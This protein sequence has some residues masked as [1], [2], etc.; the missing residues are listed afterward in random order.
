MSNIL[1][2]LICPITG[3]VLDDPIIVPCCT[4]V[5]S[6]LPLAQALELRPECPLC[7]GSLTD[8]KPLTAPKNLAIQ[9]I[10]DSLKPS[11][12]LKHTNTWSATYSCINDTLGELTINLNNSSF[13]VNPSL[14]VVVADTSGSMGGSPWA[15]VEQALLYIISVARQNPLIKVEII[16]YDSTAK[17]L[18]LT[19]NEQF[20]TNLVKSMYTGGGTNFSS[21]FQKIIELLGKYTC[22]EQ[23]AINNVSNV[24]I[25]FLT[26]GQD[27]SNNRI[28]LV[29]NFKTSLQ[30]N[31]TGA[32]NV[33]SVGFSQACDRTFLEA[34]FKSG[35]Q[36]GTF[37]YADPTDNGDTLCSKLQSIYEI[38][39][40]SSS[41]KLNLQLSGL[42]NLNGIDN[43]DILFPIDSTGKGCYKLWCNTTCDVL[44]LIVNDNEIKIEKRSN[45]NLLE[46]WIT[47]QVDN[48]ATEVYNLASNYRS[49]DLNKFK[50]AIINTKIDNIRLKTKN[51]ETITRLDFI[52]RQLNGLLVGVEVNL[53]TMSNQ[54]FGSVYGSTQPTTNKI[55]HTPKPTLTT[56]P[57][58]T[59]RRVFYT[60]NNNN[61]GRNAISEFIV[62]LT[63]NRLTS[64]ILTVID[65]TSP[66]ALMHPD[67]NGNTAFHLLAYT[68]CSNILEHLL[69]KFSK[70]LDLNILNNDKETPL[71][72]AVKGYGYFKSMNILFKHGALI[73]DGRS[74]SLQKYCISGGFIKTAQLIGEMS[75][76]C[77]EVDHS[78]SPEFVEILFNKML[79]CPKNL[80]KFLSVTMDKLMISIVIQ[81][82][83]MGVK[84]SYQQV[85]DYCFPKRPDAD[86]TDKY[87][88]LTD[89]VI[90]KYPYLLALRD[91]NGENLLFHACNRGSLPHVKYYLSHGVEIE[92]AN[93]LGNTPLWISCAKRY[94]CIIN[95]LLNSGANV[96]HMNIKGNTPLYSVCQRG[97]LK[98]AETLL[99]YGAI[100]EHNDTKR[101]SLLLVACRNGQSDI[102]RLLL[103]YVSPSFVNFK[104]DIDGFSAIFSSAEAGHE[105]CIQVLY[106]Y[107]V[108][109]NSK[110]DDNNPIIKG[111]T[112]LHLACY[113]GR[114]KAVNRL[115]S[116]GCKVNIT[117]YYGQTPLHLAVIQG[118]IE[119]VK[120]LINYKADKNIKDHQGMTA[121]NYCRDNKVLLD[122]LSNP[123][124]TYLQ[125]LAFNSNKKEILE[126]LAGCNVPSLFHIKDLLNTSE[127]C[128]SPLRNAIF[129]ND[130]DLV[131]SL[132]SLGA[133]FNTSSD[134]VND[135]TLIHLIGNQRIKSLVYTEPNPIHMENIAMAKKIDVENNMCLNLLATPKNFIV[136]KL[137][138]IHTRMSFISQLTSLN[139][140]FKPITNTINI[141]DIK[142]DNIDTMLWHTK[143]EVLVETAIGS[144]LTPLENT[145]LT[146]YINYLSSYINNYYNDSKWLEWA[147]LLY[148]AVDKL[149]KL[150]TEV[151]IGVK[152]LDRVLFKVGNIV[153]SPHFVSASSIWRV[154]TE[155]TPQ[156]EDKH[157]GT[158][159]IVKNGGR[160]YKGEV[161]LLPFT[162]YKVVNWY[163]GTNIALGQENIRD[164]TYKI[165]D[166]DLDEYIHTDK[167]LIIVLEEVN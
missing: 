143:C 127:N 6:R 51:I 7:R 89:I 108:D 163:V 116:L 164:H 83:E 73:P 166:K 38:A 98:V 153:S 95:E 151:Y 39:S 159:I 165:L 109:I 121:L 130:Y 136:E 110:T 72:L 105:D 86:D 36:D 3:E 54:R 162:Q 28:A 4:K 77:S 140:P 68:G 122:I 37:V 61:T 129:A 49:T 128:I 9:G 26:D 19:G 81:L 138:S 114:D 146:L 40:R 31:W 160:L 30:E 33:H 117:D 74:K 148:T 20:D 125:N 147:R 80:D 46:K 103:N 48:I 94:P 85:V 47:L 152:D 21:A 44:K 57:E 10:L 145:I 113:Y 154:A 50:I 99:A 15:Q 23:T 53:R 65:N 93:N 92:C 64:D 90:S 66:E 34:L 1:E 32:L 119:I 41:V 149:P 29:D 161:I 102:V 155:A 2:N 167:S 97:S 82:L 107:G 112:P 111:A 133:K 42:T 18:P 71:T 100:V 84:P 88:E 137:G 135:I 43:I 35:A 96:N 104:P 156:F 24:T 60:R 134:M 16:G 120:L 78:M 115:L 67:K 17:I 75:N 131:R 123:V 70:Q 76:L 45:P 52:S 158:V 106:E 91:Q 144:I 63:T 132:L 79:D 87:L 12:P 55:T 25:A 59:E 141:S 11:R 13:K 124:I 118:H 8:F 126:Y 14:F 150:D 139:S 22:S 157:R 27:Q 5:F 62:N 101:D 56:T 142:I 69:E 58:H